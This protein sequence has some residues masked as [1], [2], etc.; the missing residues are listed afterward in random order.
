[1][2]ALHTGLFQTLIKAVAVFVITEVYTTARVSAV[3]CFFNFFFPP[4][5]SA[6]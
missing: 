2:P 6:Q 4:E 3:S 5:Y 1:M